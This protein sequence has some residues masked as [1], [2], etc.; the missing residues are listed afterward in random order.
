[1]MP[2]VSELLGDH[3][4]LSISSVDRLYINAYVR[5]LQTPWQLIKFMRDHLGKPI[6]SLSLVNQLR[7]RFVSDVKTFAARHRI[8]LVSFRRGERKDEVAARHRARYRSAHGVVFIGVA[9]ER[10][11]A[12]KTT[13]GNH[14][15]RQPVFVNH[16]Y[17][18]VHD[19]Q[20]GPAFLKVCAYAPYAGKLCLNGHD[21]AKQQLLHDTAQAA[22]CEESQQEAEAEPKADGTSFGC[23]CR[24][25]VRSHRERCPA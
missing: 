16:Y 18:Y 11:M 15:S 6:P 19:R 3:V 7:L 24:R 14:I 25:S 23:L 17:F 5:T 8:P 22:F 12:F 2:T 13:K 1:M 20:W 9:Q 4:S 10:T 21:W